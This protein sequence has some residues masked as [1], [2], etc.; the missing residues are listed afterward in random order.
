[1][2]RNELCRDLELIQKFSLSEK[3]GEIKY[4]AAQLCLIQDNIIHE[5]PPPMRSST[6]QPNHITIATRI[7]NL[8]NHFLTWP[9]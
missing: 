1:M 6:L 2:I 7:T 4:Q 3:V 5:N 9:L 8:I